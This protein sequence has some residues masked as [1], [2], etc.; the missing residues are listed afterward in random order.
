MRSRSIRISVTIILILGIAIAALGFKNIN[1]D[2]PGFP[3][4]VRNGTGPL[5]LKLGLD[6]R[7]G[8]HLVFQADTGTRFDVT[9][10]DDVTAT[11]LN[12]A[13]EELRFGDDDVALED[14]QIFS[15]GPNRFQIRTGILA[16]DD[17][18]R[19]GLG[20]ALVEALGAVQVFQARVIEEPTPDQM[21]GVLDNITRRVNRFGTEEPIIQIFGDDRII[22]Q[23]PGASGSVT[24]IVLAEPAPGPEVDETLRTLL[25]E[26]GY[27][28]FEVDR[29]DDSTFTVRSNTVNAD[30]QSAAALAVNSEI[31]ALSQFR[32]NSGIDEAKALIGQTAE[33]V[34]KERTC[35]TQAVRP[36]H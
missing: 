35:Q 9:F 31:G 23:L 5:G 1:V 18:R 28:D 6:L 17:P 27:V 30:I 21:E 25:A 2:I 29:S 36:I 24:E 8:G 22:V 19:T 34:F 20:E 12:S 33:L 16:D 10:I 32:V 14:F 7:G 13:L 3:K 4:L 26:A 15:L 11:D